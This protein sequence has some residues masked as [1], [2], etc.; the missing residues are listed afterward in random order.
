MSE[1]R[2][3]RAARRDPPARIWRR[4]PRLCQ[5][6]PDRAR[7]RTRRQRLPLGD[8][9]PVEPRDVPDLCL[10]LGGAAQEISAQARD[11]RMGRLLRPD[12][13]RCRLRSRQHAD[14]RREG[15]RAA[16][17]HR[18]QDVD[19][20][21]ADRRRVRR[22][23][24]IR[25]ARR[26]DPRLRARERHGRPDRAQDQGEAVAARLD[27]RRDRDGRRRGRRRCAA[28][29]CRRPEGP[30]RLPQPRALRHQLGLDGRGRGLLRAPPASTRSTASSSASRSPPTSW[31][32]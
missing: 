15:R 19:H 11:G 28:A 3:A 26:Q 23:G 1:I 13:A 22:L 25:R 2:R 9:G 7:G 27:H 4:G 16:T 24:E 8:V 31:C 18:H 6:R 32:S 14:P 30:V 17:P 12:R 29:E 20:Q 5:L 10:R 21:F